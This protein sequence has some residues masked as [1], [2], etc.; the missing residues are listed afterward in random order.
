MDT[1]TALR[2][3]RRWFWTLT[4][5]AILLVGALSQEITA[6]PSPAVGVAVAVTGTLLA[7]VITQASRLMLTIGRA[8]TPTRLT[9]RRGRATDR[10]RQPYRGR[11]C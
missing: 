8:T 10:H 5:I 9:G 1:A 6:K 7:L 2:R 4:I 11:R 3:A